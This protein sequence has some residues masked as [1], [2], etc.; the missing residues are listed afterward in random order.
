MHRDVHGIAQGHE[1]RAMFNPFNVSTQRKTAATS[2]CLLYIV[3]MHEDTDGLI[4]SLQSDF[5]HCFQRRDWQ[6][7]SAFLTD[8]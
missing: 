3:K 7:V 8:T 5:Q 2:R 6:T 4:Q 1:R